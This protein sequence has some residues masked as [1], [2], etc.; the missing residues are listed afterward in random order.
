[1]KTGRLITQNA[2]HLCSSN[3]TSEEY[4]CE[5]I[6]KSSGSLE[7][8]FVHTIPRDMPDPYKQW[9]VNTSRE[10]STSQNLPSQSWV[11]KAGEGYAVCDIADNGKTSRK[12]QAQQASHKPCTAS[13]PNKIMKWLEWHQVESS[14]SYIDLALLL[15]KAKILSPYLL[16]HAYSEGRNIGKQQMQGKIKIRIT[17]TTVLITGYKVI[18]I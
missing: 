9:P 15:D 8:I 11:G 12:N 14:I 3:I 18:I 13:M 4:L 10:T 17:P 5:H 7:D 6:K 16:H 1:M 2:K